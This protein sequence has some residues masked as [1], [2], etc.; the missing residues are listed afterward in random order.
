[1]KFINKSHNAHV[2]HP[3]MYHSEQKCTHF[4]SEWW[5]VRC[6]IGALWDLLIW[7]ISVKFEETVAFNKSEN[8]TCNSLAILLPAKE[9]LGAIKLK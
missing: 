7:F 9:V 5:I 1:M 3:T 2:P 6:Q 8:V 4:C